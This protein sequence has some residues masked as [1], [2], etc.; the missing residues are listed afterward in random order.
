[1]AAQPNLHGLGRGVYTAVGAVLILY[2]F[3]GVDAEWAR[4]GLPI[5]GGILLTEGVIGYS[6]VA[7]A[8]GWGKKEHQ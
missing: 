8:L 3:F 6:M 5:V 2:G 4:Y 1:M 7:A